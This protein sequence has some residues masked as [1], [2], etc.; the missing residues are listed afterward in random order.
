MCRSKS[1]PAGPYPNGSFRCDTS[2]LSDARRSLRKARADLAERPENASVQRRLAKWEG[3]VERLE[4]EVERAGVII[5]IS[6]D[7]PDADFGQAAGQHQLLIDPETG[8][9]WFDVD[10]P[11]DEDMLHSGATIPLPARASADAKRE[12][13]EEHRD[14]IAAFIAAKRLE[15]ESGASDAVADLEYAAAELENDVHPDDW[16]D[17]L[18]VAAED[19]DIWGEVPDGYTLTD[20]G[21]SGDESHYTLT[22]PAGQSASV[23]WRP[24]DE[25]A[26]SAIRAAVDELA[27]DDDDDDNGGDV[28]GQMTQRV[29][30]TRQFEDADLPD[31]YTVDSVRD[32]GVGVGHDV[33]LR[34]TWTGETREGHFAGE[35]GAVSPQQL[36]DQLVEEI[37]DN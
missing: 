31:G 4:V 10:A 5:H 20:D 18:H 32:S 25:D 27:D 35:Y 14:Q 29:A 2:R 28:A 16:V 21:G 3:E 26:S 36:I 23:V 7:A 24:L 34:N 11:F 8:R 30:V 12:F 22:S 1:D 19:G 15:D 13:A 9:A 33:V 17:A 6:R 37:E